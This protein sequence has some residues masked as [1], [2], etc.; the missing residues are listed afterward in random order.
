MSADEPRHVPNEAPLDVEVVG[1][2]DVEAGEDSKLMKLYSH[3]W[4]Q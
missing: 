1:D 3:P 4:T 2:S